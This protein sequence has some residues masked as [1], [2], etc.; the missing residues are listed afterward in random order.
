MLAV[1]VSAA[2]SDIER[3]KATIVESLREFK[4]AFE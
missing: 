1:G 3:K 4:A 2:I